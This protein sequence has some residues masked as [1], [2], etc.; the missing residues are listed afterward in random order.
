MASAC[1]LDSAKLSRHRCPAAVAQ[2]PTSPLSSGLAW[3][4][5]TLFHRRPLSL[6]SSPSALSPCARRRSLSRL[7]RA[8][9]LSPP[10][11]RLGTASAGAGSAPRPSP[12]PA[13]SPRPSAGAATGAATAG[14]FAAAATISSHACLLSLSRSV[15]FDVFLRTFAPIS[16]AAVGALSA[17]A[18]RHPRGSLRGE[19]LGRRR[20]LVLRRGRLLAALSLLDG[21]FLTSG[22]RAPWPTAAPTAHGGSYASS[23]SLLLLLRRPLLRSSSPSPSASSPSPSPSSSSSSSRSPHCD[24]IGDA[25]PAAAARASRTAALYLARRLRLAGGASHHP[26]WS[27]N[28]RTPSGAWPTTPKSRVPQKRTATLSF[29]ASS[30]RTRAGHHGKPR[31]PAHTTAPSSTTSVAAAGPVAPSGVASAGGASS[32]STGSSAASSAGGA[33]R[34]PL[35]PAPPPPPLLAPLP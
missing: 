9:C 34:A 32:S 4:A 5:S 21:G 26:G 11:P 10:R 18:A 25:S 17:S 30:R 16:L 29:S 6:P 24:G 28:G 33:A 13:L 19:S 12:A 2:V 20:L 22:S 27:S 23:S 15:P 8:A 3:R 14:A 1:K 31:S 7:C 35:A